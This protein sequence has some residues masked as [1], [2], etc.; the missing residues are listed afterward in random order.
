MTA[1]LDSAS[2]YVNCPTYDD[3]MELQNLCITHNI[4]FEEN[5][6]VTEDYLIEQNIESQWVVFPDTSVQYKVLLKFL[7]IE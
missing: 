7:A 2:M 4:D 3:T 1:Q 5:K 6:D